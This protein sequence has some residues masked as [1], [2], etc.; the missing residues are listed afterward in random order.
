LSYVS[1]QN[2]WLV[3]TSGGKCSPFAEF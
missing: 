2:A 3:T 1:G